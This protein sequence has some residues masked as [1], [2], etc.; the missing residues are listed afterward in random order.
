MSLVRQLRDE[1]VNP[2]ISASV[3][4]RKAKILAATLNDGD[5]KQWLN[6]ELNGYPDEADLPSYRKLQAPLLGAFQGPRGSVSNYS[7]PLSMLPDSL[8]S[9]ADSLHMG[10]ALKEL[11]AMAS[12]SRK[13]NPLSQSIIFS[14]S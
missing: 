12:S 7:I 3:V 11:E 10:H 4:L 14:A 9:I 1:I 6:F 13:I 5:L 8:K 2:D